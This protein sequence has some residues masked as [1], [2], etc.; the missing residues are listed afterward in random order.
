MNHKVFLALVT[1]SLLSACSS[2][3]VDKVWPFGGDQQADSRPRRLVGATE[4]QCDSGKRFHVRYIDNNAS[5]WLIYPD[6]EV[7]LR[8]ESG[9]NRYTNGV[10]VLEVNGAEA[11]LNDGPTIA[12]SGCKVPTPAPAPA[13]K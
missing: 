1:A 12:Y 7:L 11:S 3:G 8:K 9:S 4:Y 6:H 10:A 13:A 5:A 2:M